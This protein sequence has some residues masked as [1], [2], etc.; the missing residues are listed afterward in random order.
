MSDDSSNQPAPAAPSEASPVTAP[1]CELRPH[2]TTLRDWL[3]LARISNLPTV[4]TNVMV[5]FAAAS[6]YPFNDTTVLKSLPLWDV[7]GICAAASLL[8]IGGMVL[9]DVLDADVDAKE[10]PHRPIPSGRINRARAQDFVAACFVLGVVLAWVVAP[11]H[12]TMAFFLVGA[13]VLYD[14]T[15]KR[16]AIA[17]IFMGLCRFLLYVTAGADEADPD[18][19]LFKV[20][21]CMGVYTIAITIVSRS[22]VSNVLDLRKWLAVLMPIGVLAMVGVLKPAKME[23]W[24]AA[25]AFAVS[26]WLARAVK[27]VFAKPPRTVPAILTWLSGMCLIDAYFLTLLGYPIAALIAGACFALT[28]WGHRKILGT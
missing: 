28:A 12:A 19:L 24:I 11:S 16:M 14:F 7:I 23:W 15:H 26:L 1:Q 18:D 4:W 2:R 17:V 27:F 3:E 9:N 22:E 10:R 13:V 20:A 5:G 8:Y 25:A 6:R 21:A